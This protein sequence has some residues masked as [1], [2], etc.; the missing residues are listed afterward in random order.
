M[1]SLT[2]IFSDPEPTKKEIIRR[3]FEAGHITFN[4]MWTL[5]LDEPEVIYISDPAPINPYPNPY[6]NPNPWT[7]TS[8]GTGNDNNNQGIHFT[9]GGTGDTEKH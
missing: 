3:L 6:Y 8:T 5:L 4:E 2:T 7:I 1:N 9:C